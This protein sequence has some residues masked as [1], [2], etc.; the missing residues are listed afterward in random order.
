MMSDETLTFSQFE[1]YTHFLQGANGRML[2]I[3]LRRGVGDSAFIDQIT[4]SFHERS[5]DLVSQNQSVTDDDYMIALSA[6]L[7]RIFGFGIT[8]KNA[9]RG[10]LFY[11]STWHFTLLL[12]WTNT[13]ANSR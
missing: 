9:F 7:E 6:I 1:H 5:I 8:K 3:P 11:Q 4:F 12:L 10:R 13:S 2:E